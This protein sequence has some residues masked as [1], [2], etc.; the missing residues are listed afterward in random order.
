LSQ[1]IYST[2]ESSLEPAGPGD[3]LF[4]VV[5]PLK[6]W[7]L[8]LMTFGFYQIYW[9]FKNWQNFKTVTGQ[10]MIPPL[11]GLFS[12]FFAHSLFREVDAVLEERKIAAQWSP[13]S[14]ATVYVITA[15]G[16]NLC[17]RLSKMNVGS[18][19]TDGLAVILIPVVAYVL[20][21]AQCMINL[22]MG[23]PKGVSN[24]RFT[25]WNILWILSGGIIWLAAGV[26]VVVMIFYPELLAS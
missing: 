7:L 14:L 16:N 17:D 19:V 10:T 15:I 25:V 11:R 12:I 26:G 18:P 2:P 3:T 24:S 1:D 23:D 21:R 9:F 8:F 6:F 20:Y 13:G 5:S 4:Y 22:A